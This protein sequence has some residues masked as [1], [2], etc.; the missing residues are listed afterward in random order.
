ML[1]EQMVVLFLL[2]GV[3][4][5]CYKKSIITDEVSKKL[6]AIVVN[7]ANPALVLTA[8]MGENKI[9]GEELVT[10]I[11]IMAVMYP[12][13]LLLAMILPAFL[14]VEKKVRGTY[15]AMTVFS[16]IGFMG[17]PV[18]T[19]LYGNGA[20]L[21]AT[22]FIII[23]NILI[24]T[25]G[26]SAIRSGEKAAADKK[27][28]SVKEL[29]NAGMISCIITIVM[30]IFDIPMPV[31]LQTTITHL[32]NLT[33][34][35]SMMIIGASF[36]VINVKNLFTD[37]RLL[38]FAVIKLLALPIAGIFIISMFVENQVILGVCMVM[39]A[40]P[41]GSMTAMLAQQY[42]GDY[43]TAAR[44]VALTTILSV[45]TMPLVSMLML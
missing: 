13:L 17:F 2:M 27:S 42:D 21:Y 22:P 11:A 25:Y 44:G 14:R 40:T 18:I 35:L 34:P 30:Y 16:N 45:A 12:A 15:K 9:Q 33:A 41:V 24:Y 38:V 8:C 19:A 26:V 43:E 36:A 1:L 37:V 6:S 23:Y 39:L 4:Y 3:G 10:T 20:L 32:S 7:V 31:F 28:F 29:L 5:I